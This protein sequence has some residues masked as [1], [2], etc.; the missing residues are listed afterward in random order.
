MTA[1]PAPTPTLD[2]DAPRL[3]ASNDPPLSA[4][5]RTRLEKIAKYR[6]FAKSL[7]ENIEAMVRQRRWQWVYTAISIVV[8]AVGWHWSRLFAGGA[9][10]T[11]VGCSL[12]GLYLSY[13]RA[14]HY[15]VEL[16]KTLEEIETLE[17]DAPG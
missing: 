15:L 11:G 17:G 8:G 6:A 16:D 12:T 3:D 5:E 1:S 7:E 13:V 4:A 2:A 9:V 10:A 14:A